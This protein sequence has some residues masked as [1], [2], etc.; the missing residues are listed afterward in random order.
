LV[1]ESSQFLTILS[2]MQIFIARVV[3]KKL[4]FKGEYKNRLSAFRFS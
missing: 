1:K 3:E 4:I 2:F